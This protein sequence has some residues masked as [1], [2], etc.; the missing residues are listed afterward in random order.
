[1]LVKPAPGRNQKVIT[2][3][4]DHKVPAT[5]DVSAFMLVQAG[6]NLHKRNSCLGGDETGVQQITLP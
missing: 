6:Q 1:M 3:S 2:K 5:A 4:G